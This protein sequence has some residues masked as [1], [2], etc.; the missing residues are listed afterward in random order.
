MEAQNRSGYANIARARDPIK[1]AADRDEC[2]AVVSTAMNTWV[3]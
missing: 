3:S 1:L 2:A